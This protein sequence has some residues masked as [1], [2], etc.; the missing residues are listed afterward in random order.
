MISW[1]EITWCE[2]ERYLPNTPSRVTRL[3]GF[4]SPYKVVKAHMERK[5]VW[6]W[7]VV[8]PVLLGV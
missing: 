4:L 8:C 3:D 6:S 1:E 5:Q 2:A 7:D